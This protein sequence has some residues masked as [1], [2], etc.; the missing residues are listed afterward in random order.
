LLDE[1]LESLDTPHREVFVLFEIEQMTREEV[2]EALR[3][4][5][6]TVA[7]R[8]RKAREAFR[9]AAER[10]QARTRRLG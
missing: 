5:P 1:A 2:A 3:I 8:L 4:P 10:L 9:A 7:S 6:G